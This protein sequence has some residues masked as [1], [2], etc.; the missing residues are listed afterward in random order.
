MTRGVK[1]ALIT[2]LI[3]GTGIGLYFILKKASNE[4]RISTSNFNPE[5]KTITINVGKKIFQYQ[6]K[7]G[8]LDL[9]KVDGFHSA[10]VV[11][12]D[13]SSQNEADYIDIKLMKAGK[14]INSKR[15][16]FG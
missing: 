13:N 3:G 16:Y 4:P 7:P 6:F 2:V 1:I 8:F 11:A 14:M 12:Y 10:Q 15:V 5:S 9:G